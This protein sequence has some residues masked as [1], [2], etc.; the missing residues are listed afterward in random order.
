MIKYL[1]LAVICAISTFC[2]S[3]ENNTIKQNRYK[4]YISNTKTYNYH[5]FDRIEANA[6]EYTSFY[7]NGEFR[8][9]IHIAY[10]SFSML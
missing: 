6:T 4:V 7:K 9:L 5:F 3:K 8:K 1:I 2:T 10:D